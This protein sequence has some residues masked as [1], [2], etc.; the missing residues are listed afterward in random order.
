M[1]KKTS[2]CFNCCAEEKGL[3]VVFL[4]ALSNRDAGKRMVITLCRS[5]EVGM[6][7]AMW[8]SDPSVYSTLAGFIDT[9]DYSRLVYDH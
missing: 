5:Q 9:A 3:I 4:P 8:A 1:D 7:R 6:H 2:A